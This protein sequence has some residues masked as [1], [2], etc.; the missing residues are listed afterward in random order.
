MSSLRRAR[1]FAAW[2]LGIYLAGMYVRLGWGEL[3]SDGLWGESF[4]HLDHT[5]WLPGLIGGIEVL[6][7]AALIVPWLAS[8]AGFVL[9]V[10]TAAA[11]GSFAHEHRWTDVARV[12]WYTVALTWIAYEWLWLRVGSG[13]RR[14]RSGGAEA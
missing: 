14:A 7:G 2:L 6:G 10:I 9:S 11:W 13:A 3:E 4:T 8:Y 12:T 1:L 5:P